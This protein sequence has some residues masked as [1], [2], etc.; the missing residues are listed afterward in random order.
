[1]FLNAF[2]LILNTSK[3]FMF[4]HFGYKRIVAKQATQQFPHCTYRR[5][6]IFLPM[7]RAIK[8]FYDGV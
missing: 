5:V 7:Y 6:Y 1:M 8:M 4:T 2:P 3:D